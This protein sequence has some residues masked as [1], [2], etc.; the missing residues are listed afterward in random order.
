MADS[1]MPFFLTRGVVLLT[2]DIATGNWVEMAR[3]AHLTTIATHIRPAEVARFL[4]TE[5][6]H[7]FVDECKA[8]QIQVEHELHGMGE[9]LPREL[10]AKAPLMFRMN[11]Q[12]QR[13][14]DA[15][16]CVHSRD[17]LSVVCENAVSFAQVLRPTTGRYF[18]WTDDAPPMCRC[19]ECRGLSDSDQALI[20]ENALIGA[21][22]GFDSKA[23]LAHL[24]YWNTLMPPAQIKPAPG[25]FLEFAPI[26][27]SSQVPLRCKE[28][29]GGGPKGLSHSELLEAL[30]A[31]LSVFGADN[32]QV[33]EYWLDVSRFSNWKREETVKVPWDCHVLEEDLQT[34]SRLGIRHVT[35]FACW[36]D[37]DY[38]ARFGEPPVQE[39]GDTLLKFR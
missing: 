16:L 7:A 37:G 29:H 1:G 34:Y 23:T 22:R 5:E 17:A 27:R 35:S 39:Y 25:V 33:L 4:N 10:F 19:P 31:N 21:L 3:R 12:G 38:V 13:T 28:K 24:A 2:Q 9:L 18:Y 30:D 36:I 14:P 6:G 8:L 26:Q 15:N 32:A 11:E 20:L